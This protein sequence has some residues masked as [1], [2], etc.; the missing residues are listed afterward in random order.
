MFPEIQ[1]ELDLIKEAILAK[2]PAEEIY[3]FGSY[4]S[5]TPNEES[6]IDLYVV[7]PDDTAT[8]I[9]DLRTAIRLSLFNKQRRPLDLL[10]GKRSV[11][12]RVKKSITL[13]NLI[14]KQ[15]VKIYG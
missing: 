7:I 4:A 10:M 15:G 13:E 12:D 3:L 8:D 11:F 2:V 9:I 1:Q 6:D 14:F 5:G